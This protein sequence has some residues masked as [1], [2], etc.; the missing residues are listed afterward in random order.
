MSSSDP[1]S[2][3]AGGL[4][5]LRREYARAG[6]DE[7]SSAEDPFAQ[8]ARWF[9]EAATAPVPEPNAMTLATCGADGVPAARI[10]LLKGY[11]AEGFVFYTNYASAK[12]RA[13]DANPNVALLFFWPE[14]ERQIRVAGRASKVARAES[15]AYFAKRPRG[16]QIG[17]WASPQ[18]EPIA[19][20]DVLE[21]RAAEL[22]RAYQGKT[23]PL[24]PA[25]GGYRV[26]PARFEFWQGRPNRLHDRIAY[27][28][29]GEGWR[30]ERLAP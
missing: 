25:W 27:V 17:A 8:F 28:R 19:A 26:A 3:D 1:P 23:V 6:L 12:A 5:T 2:F 10:V 11:D 7:A 24:P 30:R 22:D 21:Q 18:S 14:L 16:S 13:I 20:R 15:E 4:A 9:S 29:D